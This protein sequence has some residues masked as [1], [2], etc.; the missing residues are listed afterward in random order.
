MIITNI[1]FLVLKVPNLIAN[2][3][4]ILDSNLVLQTVLWFL[5]Y[6]FYS[7]EFFLQLAI[8]NIVRDA[9]LNVLI[10]SWKKFGIH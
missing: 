9:F 7:F 10:T 6:L 1:M 5:L 3:M 4:D 2:F 8:N